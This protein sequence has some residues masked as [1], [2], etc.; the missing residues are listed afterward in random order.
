MI[1][2][3]NSRLHHSGYPKNHVRDPNF[4]V[5]LSVTF[6][7]A[8]RSGS[9]DYV[10]PQLRVRNS[11]HLLRAIMPALP[12][13]E[14][15]QVQRMASEDAKA[16]LVCLEYEKEFATIA[17]KLRCVRVLG[18]LLLYAPNRDVRIEVTKCILSCEDDNDLVN[19]DSFFERYVILPCEFFVCHSLYA[20][21]MSRLVQL[22][23]T[24]VERQVPANTPR[25]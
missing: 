18:F 12:A 6:S 17:G 16:Y 4:E 25:I 24:K 2:L 3:S 9:R 7:S 14:D 15:P 5:R 23:S 11:T 13:I 1:M 19:L 21:S 20:K 10:T 22:R 8:N